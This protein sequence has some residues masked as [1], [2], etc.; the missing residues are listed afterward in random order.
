MLFKSSTVLN[1]HVYT[2]TGAKPYSCRH[3]SECYRQLGHLKA[4]L[5]K[6]HNEGTWFTC[7]ICE[8]KFTY[9]SHLKVHAHRHEDVKPYV[10]CEC[11]KAF[12][13]GTEL[14]HHVVKHSNAKLF[15]CGLCAKDFKYKKSVPIH[16]KRCA[17]EHGFTGV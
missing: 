7:H 13:T 4:H 11:S 14:R 5:L 9:S 17:V 8:K 2:H 6:S 12:C 3:C 1:K 15:C 16:F 10:C